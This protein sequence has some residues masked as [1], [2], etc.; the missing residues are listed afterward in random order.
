MKK[1]MCTFAAERNIFDTEGDECP[2]IVYSRPPRK[3]Q[4]K[5][6]KTVQTVSVPFM[7]L[8]ILFCVCLIASN[9]LVSKVI[10][11]GPFSVTAG[12][13]VFPV[14]YIINDC[15]A[16]V[17][18]FKKARLII[19]MGFFMNF[20]VAALGLLAIAIPA[21]PYWHNDEAFNY[22]FGL[23]PQVALG[24]FLAFIVG[25]F[26]NAYIMSKM[27]IKSQGKHFSLRAIISTIGGEGFDSLI[28][29]PIALGG[30]FSMSHIL[31]LIIVEVVLKT[32]YEI[33][34]LPITIRVVNYIKD[35]EGMDVYDDNI[36]YNILKINDL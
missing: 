18:G 17:W 8:G 33:L 3:K 7:L 34:I 35:L 28:F 16:E 29:F 2:Q 5:M 21:A 13:L 23:V 14:S 19:W 12:I 6:K 1:K 4:E 26:V 9:L 22:V 27:K 24:S 20:F 11:L 15:I 10:Q 30:H 25:S 32:L 31:G 36:S